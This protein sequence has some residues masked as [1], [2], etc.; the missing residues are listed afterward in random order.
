MDST[1][2][3]LRG[4]GVPRG[5]GGPLRAHLRGQCVEEEV[6]VFEEEIVNTVLS[7]AG[8]STEITPVITTHAYII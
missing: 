7:A 8:T 6:D 1:A 2:A 4:D 3:G 5:H